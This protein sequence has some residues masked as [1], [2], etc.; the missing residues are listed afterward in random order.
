MLEE[1]ENIPK[2]KLNLFFTEEDNDK[3]EAWWLRWREY[4]PKAIYNRFLKF[5]K[6]EYGRIK[7]KILKYSIRIFR[8]VFVISVLFLGLYGGLGVLKKFGTD[9]ILYDKLFSEGEGVKIQKY[10]GKGFFEFLFSNIRSKRKDN[11]PMEEQ[12][13]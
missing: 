6:K 7:D 5:I 11:L 4:T 12:E 2:P 13:D 8:V 9:K 3:K 10:E 1:K